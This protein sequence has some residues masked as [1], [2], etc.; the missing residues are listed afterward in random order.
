M[1]THFTKP[2][3]LGKIFTR[4]KKTFK[5]MNTLGQKATKRGVRFVYECADM[6]DNPITPIK[7]F[8]LTEFRKLKADERKLKNEGN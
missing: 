8:N 7:P 4:G 5:I 2:Q 1:K 6:K 3:M